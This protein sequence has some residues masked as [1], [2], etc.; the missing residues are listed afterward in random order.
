MKSTAVGLK[1]TLVDG[2]WISTVVLVMVVWHWYA[3]VR[4]GVPIGVGVATEKVQ[5]LLEQYIGQN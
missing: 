5:G 4:Y 1:E 2:G 3:I